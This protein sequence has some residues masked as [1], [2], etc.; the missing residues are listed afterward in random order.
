MF[1]IYFLYLQMKVLL[2]TSDE[3]AYEEF[4]VFD[5]CRDGWIL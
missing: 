4:I 5:E 2:L 3:L 1:S